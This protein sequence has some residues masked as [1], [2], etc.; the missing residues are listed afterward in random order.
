M[1]NLFQ[2]VNNGK[3]SHRRRGSI[4]INDDT[5]LNKLNGEDGNSSAIQ[6]VA[7][8]SYAPV[9][10]QDSSQMEQHMREEWA[11][12]QIQTAFRGFLVLVLSLLC[13][14]ALFF[15]LLCTTTRLV[16]TAEKLVILEVTISTHS[17][18]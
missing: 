2:K 3:F 12:T 1:H 10:V 14:Y 13:T 6:A 11:A 17:Y 7:S 9:H 16:F 18:E 4:E 15:S 8:S 5:F